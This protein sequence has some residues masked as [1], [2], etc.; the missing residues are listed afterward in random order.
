MGGLGCRESGGVGG[1]EGMK[2]IQVWTLYS[3]PLIVQ[4]AIM[5]PRAMLCPLLAGSLWS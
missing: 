5:L 1:E 3:L 2:G 4:Q